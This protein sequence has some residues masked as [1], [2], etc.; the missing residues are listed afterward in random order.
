VREYLETTVAAG[1]AQAVHEPPAGDAPVAVTRVRV[2]GQG[3]GPVVQGDDVHVDL[4]ITVHRAVRGLQVLVG[5]SS[6]E[7]E[8]VCAACNGDYRA[9]W[10]VE[11][12]VY[13]VSVCFADARLMPRA[14][15]VSV[16]AFAQWG[17]DLFHDVR[18]AATF[19]VAA[20]DVL[21]TG[22]LP[23]ADRGVTWIPARFAIAPAPATTDGAPA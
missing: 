4:G 23:A 13:T 11:S 19:R 18:N 12:G 15:T 6:L 2:R 22:I 21:G 8:Q 14:Y 20:R 1:E 5:I 3:G 7:G 10:D 17:R 16:R 9:E